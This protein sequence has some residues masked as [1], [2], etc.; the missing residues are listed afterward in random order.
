MSLLT[1]IVLG[2]IAGLAASQLER[3]QGECSLSTWHSGIVGAIVGALIFDRFHLADGLDLYSALV[4]GIG[5][6]VVVAAYHLVFAR[7]TSA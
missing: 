4:A 7:R 3:P 2:S 1:W 6:V 5:P